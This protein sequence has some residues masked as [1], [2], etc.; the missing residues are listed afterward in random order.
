MNDKNKE[1]VFRFKLVRYPFIYFFKIRHGGGLAMVAYEFMA[2][3]G[4]PPRGAEE[5]SLI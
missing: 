2:W 1:Q 4:T 3:C 5:Y